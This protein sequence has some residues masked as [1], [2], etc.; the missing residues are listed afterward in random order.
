MSGVTADPV[1]GET[2]LF[3]VRMASGNQIFDPWI[4]IMFQV[5]RLRRVKCET[6]PSQSCDHNSAICPH[7]STLFE[8][9]LHVNVH[10]STHL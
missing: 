5:S 3:F 2:V 4:Y 9:A 1:K 8:H 7:D 10:R 6:E